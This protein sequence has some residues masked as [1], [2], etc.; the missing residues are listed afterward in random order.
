LKDIL[1]SN[2][3]IS[4]SAIRNVNFD[5]FADLAIYPNPVSAGSFLNIR[6]DANI[7]GIQL[8]NAIGQQVYN[9]NKPTANVEIPSDLAAGIYTLVVD[10]EGSQIIRK[11][12]V[13]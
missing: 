11:L 1:D 4:Y 12:V 13:E 5:K 3:E 6:L 8:Y 10:L 7:H 2:N 9:L